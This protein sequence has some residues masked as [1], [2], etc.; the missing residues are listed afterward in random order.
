M[1]AY[2]EDEYT[3]ATVWLRNDVKKLLDEFCTEKGDKMKIV[4]DAILLHLMDL[5]ARAEQ[6][7]NRG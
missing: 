5:L 7:I 4:N 3:R 2:F 6:S 1:A